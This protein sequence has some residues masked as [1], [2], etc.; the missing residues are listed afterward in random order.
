MSIVRYAGNGGNLA[1]FGFALIHKFYILTYRIVATTD[2]S[3]CAAVLEGAHYCNY[4]AGRV[5][6]PM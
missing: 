4:K 3:F 2:K 5:M 1:I 6:L